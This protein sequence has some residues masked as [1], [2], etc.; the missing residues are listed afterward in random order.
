MHD[1]ERLLSQPIGRL[2]ERFLQRERPVP[3]GLLEALDRDERRAAQ[4]LARAIRAR[5]HKTRAGGQRLRTLLRYEVGR[6][7]T[8]HPHVAGGDEAGMAPLAGPV[9]AAAVVPPRSY[10]LRGIDDSKA[11]APDPRQ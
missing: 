1:L 7:E 2:R 10:R 4:E 6:W 8:G 11:L 5:Q 3:E 9:V